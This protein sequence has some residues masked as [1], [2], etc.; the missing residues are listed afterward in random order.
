MIV[1]FVCLLLNSIS[2][3]N[4]GMFHNVGIEYYSKTA[5]YCF[6][7]K[8]MKIKWEI[9]KYHTVRTFTKS[10]RKTLECGSY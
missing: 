2:F 8:F 6:N 5:Y 3:E 1:A 10:N 7:M 9:K 4:N